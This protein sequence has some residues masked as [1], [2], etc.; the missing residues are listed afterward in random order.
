MNIFQDYI[1]R[2]RVL[3]EIWTQKNILVCNGRKKIQYSTWKIVNAI[4][5]CTTIDGVRNVCHKCLQAV[6]QFSAK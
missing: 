1:Q 4:I 5:G 6:L 2:S 3:D